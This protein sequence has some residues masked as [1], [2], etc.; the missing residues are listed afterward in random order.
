[1]KDLA[2]IPKEDLEKE[3]RMT[4]EEM[5]KSSVDWSQVPRSIRL[6]VGHTKMNPG[7]RKG[8]VV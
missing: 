7:I 1:M 6:F 5:E 2:Q 4:K 8:R 3:L